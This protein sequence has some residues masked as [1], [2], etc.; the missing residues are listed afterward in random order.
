MWGKIPQSLRQR[1]RS[2]WDSPLLIFRCHCFWPFFWEIIFPFAQRNRSEYALPSIANASIRVIGDVEVKEYHSPTG[3]CGERECR[4]NSL[5]SDCHRFIFNE[6]VLHDRENTGA[7]L[8]VGVMTSELTTVKAGKR[9]STSEM[10]VEIVE[11]D[12]SR[13]KGTAQIRIFHQIHS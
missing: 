12:E 8:S 3:S 1:E 7:K 5:R 2:F 4:G 13:G 11:T 6:K 9:K 10:T